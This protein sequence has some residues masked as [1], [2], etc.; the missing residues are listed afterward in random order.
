MKKK[1]TA[2]VMAISIQTILF[3]LGHHVHHSIFMLLTHVYEVTF[4]Y[5]STGFKKM[6]TTHRL[7]TTDI[8]YL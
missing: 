7:R 8:L 2:Y 6:F 1:K 3:Y 5:K 4:N